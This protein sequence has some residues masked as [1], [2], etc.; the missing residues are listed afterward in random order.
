M[1]IKIT[2]TKVIDVTPQILAEAFWELDNDEQAIFFD[3]LAT[4]SKGLLEDQM[5][6]VSSFAGGRSLKA[7][8]AMI[9]IGKDAAER[10]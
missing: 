10:K 4:V 7:L 2:E 5:Q 8:E 1:K 6:A 9:S 3:H